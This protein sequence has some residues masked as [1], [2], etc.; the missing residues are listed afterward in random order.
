[1]LEG[2]EERGWDL[3]IIGEEVDYLFVED[4]VPVIAV[5][6]VEGADCLDVI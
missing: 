1:M 6:E 5:L 2:I 4:V 3:D